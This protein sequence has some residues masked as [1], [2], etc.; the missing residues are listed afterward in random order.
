MNEI[1]IVSLCTTTLQKV[2]YGSH[3]KFRFG[4]FPVELLCMSMACWARND[5]LNFFTQFHLVRVN[6]TT[7]N[8][9]KERQDLKSGKGITRKVIHDGINLR[10]RC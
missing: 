10:T 7:Q 8:N 1:S 2:A 4:A 9:A 5:S 3:I 6:K